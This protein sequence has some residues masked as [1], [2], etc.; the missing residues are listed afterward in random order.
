MPDVPLSFFVPRTK[1]VYCSTF[2]DRKCDGGPVGEAVVSL[3]GELRLARQ[4][5]EG[6]QIDSAANPAKDEDCARNFAA[7]D[8]GITSTWLRY[9]DSVED[10]DDEEGES[11]AAEANETTSRTLV[12]PCSDPSLPSP[13]V[14]PYAEADVSQLIFLF[15]G[16]SIATINILLAAPLDIP[17]DPLPSSDNGTS[18]SIKSESH[19]SI[20]IP[21]GADSSA[22]DIPVYAT[23]SVYNGKLN[24]VT[25]WSGSTVL[26]AMHYPIVVD[27]VTHG[28][29]PPSRKRPLRC[30]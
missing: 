26:S 7:A 20:D 3:R 29:S 24:A 17:V 23:S 9:R 11:A 1:H 12:N 4:Q 18:D 5:P 10:E 16:L 6:I 21:D 19:S 22:Y 27:I 14:T 25:K 13:Y 15:A 8:H 30:A 28:L 2:D